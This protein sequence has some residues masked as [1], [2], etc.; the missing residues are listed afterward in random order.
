MWPRLEGHATIRSIPEDFIVEEQLGFETDGEGE[1]LLIHIRKKSLNTDQVARGLAR[2]AGIAR[3]QVSFAGMKDR[4][5]VTSQYFS[6]HLPG[7]KPEDEPDWTALQSDQLEVLSSHRHKRKLRRGALKANRF[8]LRLRDLDIEPAVIDTRLNLIMKRGVPNYFMGQRFGRQC[9]NL[10]QAE[11]MLI[12]GQRIRDRHL[13]GVYLSAARSW[14]FNQV[15]SAR[16]DAN[17]W[18]T[19]LA[20]D[21][22]LLDHS[23]SCFHVDAIDEDLSRRLM[24]GSVHPTGPLWGRGDSMVSSTASEFELGALAEWQTW[25]AGLEKLGLESARRRLRVIVRDLQWDRP[26]KEVLDLRFTL[27]PGCYATAVLRELVACRPG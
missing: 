27:P 2:H 11:K 4:N 18:D 19:G 23:R 16:I 12:D 6:V 17:C 13:R 1:H 21:C 8:K 24:A 7:I 20:G 26:E 3:K 14:L 22:M 10:V 25:M 5:A 9:N 15:L